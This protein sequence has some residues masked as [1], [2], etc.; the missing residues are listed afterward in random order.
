MQL[1]TYQL[2]FIGVISG[3]KCRLSCPAWLPPWISGSSQGVPCIQGWMSPV[4][5]VF[6]L[7]GGPQ[8]ALWDC[9]KQDAQPVPH[10]DRRVPIWYSSS[11]RPYRDLV[12]TLSGFIH[13]FLSLWDPGR[14]QGRSRLGKNVRVR[15]CT[16]RFSK[17]SPLPLSIAKDWLSLVW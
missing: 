6:L 17:Y 1:K 13:I 11:Q 12:E 10:F 9:G 2:S 14:S 15:H 3:P 5:H 8:K 16:C 4:W 7:F